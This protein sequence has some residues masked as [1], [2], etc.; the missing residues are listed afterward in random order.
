MAINIE[1][2][3]KQENDDYMV[4]YPKADYTNMNGTLDIGNTTGSLDI[5]SRSTGNLPLSRTTGNLETSRLTGKIDVN[6]YC[7]GN[8]SISGYLPT[9]P[10]IYFSSSNSN[11]QP[12]EE[13]NY[14]VGVSEV[15]CMLR[16]IYA[17]GQLNW[18]SSTYVGTGGY[19]DIGGVSGLES[20]LIYP[21]QQGSTTGGAFG[22][23]WFITIESIRNKK[24]TSVINYTNNTI[25]NI[26][27]SSYITIYD[28]PWPSGVSTYECLR[29]NS[30]FSVNG[31]TY[32]LLQIYNLNSNYN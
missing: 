23:C 5:G 2:N 26:S 10:I 21:E 3:L 24:W 32:R 12:S 30:N 9:T 16:D 18:F 19:L 20:I 17:T 7:T 13:A 14:V 1:M 11:N 8:F 6:T 29:V 31:V 28:K 27:L 15:M 22:L 4:M 25:S